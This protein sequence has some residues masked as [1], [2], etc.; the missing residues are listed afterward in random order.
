MFKIFFVVIFAFV[1]RADDNDTTTTTPW[2]THTTPESSSIY[3]DYFPEPSEEDV[4]NYGDG[5]CQLDGSF[6]NEQLFLRKIIS[7]YDGDTFV[8]D[9]YQFPASLVTRVVLLNF[10]RYHGATNA[11][12]II[13]ESGDGGVEIYVDIFSGKGIRMFVE[14]Y[15]LKY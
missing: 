8:S 1:V 7:T 12:D 6:P 9:S 11:I 5:F 4:G 2:T 15:G 14:V 3:C 10:G 13:N